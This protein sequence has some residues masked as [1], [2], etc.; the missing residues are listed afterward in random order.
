M[1][2]LY[3]TAF[4]IVL[5]F[6]FGEKGTIL[7]NKYSN[8]ALLFLLFIIISISIYH[9]DLHSVPYLKNYLRRF[10]NLS[11]LNFHTLIDHIKITQEPMFDILQ[12]LVAKSTGSFRLF[13]IIVWGIIFYNFYKAVRNLFDSNTVIFVMVSYFSFF[14]FFNYVLNVMRQGLAISFI[15]L[16]ISLLRS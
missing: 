7:N 14:I 11:V 8:N 10:D 1:I 6:S 12:W 4:L 3:I 13:V 2:F 5:L 16:S 15:F 9:V